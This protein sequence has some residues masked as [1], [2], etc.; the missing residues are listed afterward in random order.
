VRNK[1]VDCVPGILDGI[2]VLA[3]DPAPT[4]VPFDPQNTANVNGGEGAIVPQQLFGLLFP[5]G[6]QAPQTTAA[7]TFISA[8][9]K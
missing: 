3:S 4:H 8:L 7:I 9:P 5:N 1:N 6:I 2:S